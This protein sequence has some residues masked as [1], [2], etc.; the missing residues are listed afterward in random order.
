MI[1]KIN[2]KLFIVNKGIIV[3]P[4]TAKHTHKAYK[5]RKNL[6]EHAFYEKRGTTDSTM[7]PQQHARNSTPH[8]NNTR[9]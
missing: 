5:K 1:K 6:Q 8:R 7:H 3:T 9:K 2:A 4:S